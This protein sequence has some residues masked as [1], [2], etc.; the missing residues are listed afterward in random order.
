MLLFGTLG[1]YFVFFLIFIRSV[2][3]HTYN[4][5]G[6]VHLRERRARIC[7]QSV[8]ILEVEN[9]KNSLKVLPALLCRGSPDQC[10]NLDGRGRLQRTSAFIG[11]TCSSHARGQA[12]SDM[13]GEGQK[14]GI[15]MRSRRVQGMF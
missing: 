14:Y 2:S 1:S 4:A 15:F 12:V 13:H 5:L 10:S 6:S 9:I 3:I 8:S 7:T 11:R